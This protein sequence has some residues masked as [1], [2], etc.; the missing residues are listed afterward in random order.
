[1]LLFLPPQ[2]ETMNGIR[3]NGIKINDKVTLK[4][5]ILCG[6]CDMPAKA[7]VLNMC[8]FNAFYGC[9]K[10]TQRGET[11]MTESGGNVRSFPFK[12]ENPEGPSR[13]H[14]ETV[15]HAKN[16][17]ESTKKEPICG[18]KGPSALLLLPSLCQQYC[19]RSC[20]GLYARSPTWS[21]E[22]LFES[23]A[24]QVP[25]ERTFFHPLQCRKCRE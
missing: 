11:V 1:M 4:G 12:P 5:M 23:L 3:E 19:Q 25:Q 22:T 14:I 7:S 15:Q 9:P 21:D 17:L 18:I 24:R 6:T 20:S 8:Q 2:L 10:C 13:T 16:V